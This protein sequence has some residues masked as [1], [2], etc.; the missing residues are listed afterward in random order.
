MN[1]ELKIVNRIK[2]WNEWIVTSLESSVIFI[3]MNVFSIV[4]NF[5][6]DKAEFSAAVCYSS[7][8]C[9]MILQKALMCAP[10]PQN[11]S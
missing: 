8:Q 10:G 11:K 2:S 1:H 7:F 3:K 4:N 9:H 5:C 6:G